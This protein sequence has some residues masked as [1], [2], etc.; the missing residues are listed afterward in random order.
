MICEVHC[1]L[2]SAKS[3]HMEKKHDEGV[4]LSMPCRSSSKTFAIT[5]SIAL[6]SLKERL[7][8]DEEDE[9]ITT[10]VAAT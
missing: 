7:R 2:Q 3:V 8:V 10:N 1:E 4:C 5:P 9:L 6:P